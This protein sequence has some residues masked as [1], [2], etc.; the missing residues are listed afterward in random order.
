MLLLRGNGMA[1]MALGYPLVSTSTCTTKSISSSSFQIF[2]LSAIFFA[3]EIALM[4]IVLTRRRRIVDDQ[5]FVHA[6]RACGS[7]SRY[8]ESRRVASKL[9]N[10][11]RIEL[12]SLRSSR[13]FRV[14]Q[15]LP[16]THH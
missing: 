3:L 12:W 13:N 9:F 11:G 5:P 10:S 4:S 6:I 7:I 15:L 8:H 14:L 1:F 16:P 2:K